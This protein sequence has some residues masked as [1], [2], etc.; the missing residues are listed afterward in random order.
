MGT[1]ISKIAEYQEQIEKRLASALRQ[2][3]SEQEDLAKLSSRELLQ[4]AWDRAEEELD[5]LRT[6]LR[7]LRQRHQAEERAVL[8]R[9]NEKKRLQRDL[10]E[11]APERDEKAGQLNVV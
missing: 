9:I 7:V 3:H 5:A 8:A 10:L 1:S 2:Q 11:R 4:L 6:Q